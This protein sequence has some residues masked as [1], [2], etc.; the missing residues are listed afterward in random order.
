MGVAVG[1]ARV[2]HARIVGV[3]VRADTLRTVTITASQARRLTEGRA[4]VI[5]EFRLTV[6]EPEIM[7]VVQVAEL[8]GKAPTT[9]YEMAKRG[10]IPFE[11]ASG[12][13]GG[14]RLVFHR[15]RI[16]RWVALRKL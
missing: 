2:E 8:L 4:V 15:E 6:A 10:V 9:V 7:D 13:R 5:E 16:M 3:L 14:R 1:G 11:R 12:E